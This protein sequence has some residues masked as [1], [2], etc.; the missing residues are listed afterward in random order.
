MTDTGVTPHIDVLQGA[1]K[2]LTGP[3]R[4]ANSIGDI[5]ILQDFHVAGSR[6]R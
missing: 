5:E 6:G 3:D 2:T 4:F 1:M